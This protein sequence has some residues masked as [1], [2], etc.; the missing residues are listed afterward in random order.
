MTTLDI[1][2]LKRP[3]DEFADALSAALNAPTLTAAQRREAMDKLAQRVMID[4]APAVAGRCGWCPTRQRLATMPDGK[5]RLPKFGRLM[6]S[7]SGRC[8]LGAPCPKCTRAALDVIRRRVDRPK[9][10]G[11][12]VKVRPNPGVLDQT[13]AAPPGTFH[14]Q[15]DPFGTCQFCRKWRRI[16]PDA[17]TLTAGGM[18]Q[19]CPPHAWNE[20]TWRTWR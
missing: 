8:A 9:S 16:H 14:S 18:P 13:S 3:E 6:T 17:R 20:P 12:A 7:Q 10:T 11:G 5:S 2:V 19:G 4:P 15:H 1:W